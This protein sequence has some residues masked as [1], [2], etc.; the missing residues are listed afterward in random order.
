MVHIWKNLEKNSYVKNQGPGISLE[1]QWLRLHT[2]NARCDGSIPG[3]GNNIPH[4][5]SHGQKK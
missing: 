3:Q 2:S 5:V 1:D 4:A